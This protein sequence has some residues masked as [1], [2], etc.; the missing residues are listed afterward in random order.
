M[1]FPLVASKIHP[2]IDIASCTVSTHNTEKANTARVVLGNL[3]R[4]T[5]ATYTFEISLFAGIRNV[6]PLLDRVKRYISLSN[7]TKN[8]RKAYSRP[9]T[10]AKSRST[11]NSGVSKAVSF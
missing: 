2:F 10:S 5:G 7:T 11:K 6:L 9:S 3:T 8:W 1:A 4:E